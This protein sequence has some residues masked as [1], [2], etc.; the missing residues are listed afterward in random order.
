MG[1]GGDD[2]EMFMEENERNQKKTY[3]AAIEELSAYPYG[4]ILTKIIM[5]N[6]VLRFDSCH[7]PWD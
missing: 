3:G 7:F 2:M 4:G 5:M 1:G 6:F